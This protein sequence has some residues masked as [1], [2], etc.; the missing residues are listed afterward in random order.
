MET[1]PFSAAQ[2][3]PAIEIVVKGDPP[4][5]ASYRARASKLVPTQWKVIAEGDNLSQPVWTHLLTPEDVGESAWIV[6]RK[7]RLR[8]RAL[9][10]ADGTVTIRVRQEETE[11]YTRTGELSA[12]D[13]WTLETG[14]LIL[15]VV[16]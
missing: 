12:A 13:G 14:M 1:L 7:Y 6:G 15:E 11:L 10:D 16:A 2:A 4:P 9:L 5:R 3:D 8:V